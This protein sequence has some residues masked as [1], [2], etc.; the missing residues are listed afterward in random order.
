MQGWHIIKNKKRCCHVACCSGLRHALWALV[1]SGSA[2]KCSHSHS[3]L[4]QV[5]G[6]S[7]CFRH[8]RLTV[9]L[10]QPSALLPSSC[11]VVTSSHGLG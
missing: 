2:D 4:V 1:G 6:G 9:E 11:S 7:K 5:L 3:G 10:V 8:C